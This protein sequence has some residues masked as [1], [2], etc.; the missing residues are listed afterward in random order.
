MNEPRPLGPGHC[1][2][3]LTLVMVAS[4]ASSWANES[5]RAS[6]VQ[7][8]TNTGFETSTDGWD[9]PVPDQVEWNPEDAQGDPVSGSVEAVNTSSEVESDTVVLRQC[10]S[11]IG[12]G[13][14]RVSASA[15]I[16]GGQ[17]TTGSVVARL[18]VS[19]DAN[20]PGDGFIISGRFVT[21]D[22]EGWQTEQW[23]KSVAA[24]TGSALVEVA[25][26]KDQTGG[27]LAVRIDDV[28]LTWLDSVFSDRFEVEA[29]LELR[30]KTCRAC[31]ELFRGS[32]GVQSQQVI[33]GHSWTAVGGSST[34][35]GRRWVLGGHAK[36]RHARNERISYM[37]TAAGDDQYDGAAVR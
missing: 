28:R 15:R 33:P 1:V 27:E 32:P 3:A 13:I 24:G 2:V 12:R 23:E 19:N 11:L 36:R 16:L 8:L 31:D 26:R 29:G 35:A 17:E 34:D 21:T 22:A 20:C 25:V 4:I 37:M 10:V 7:L 5:A 18:I 30:A 6:E 14:Y 9:L